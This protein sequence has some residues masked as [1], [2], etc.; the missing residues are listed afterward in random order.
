MTHQRNSNEVIY[1]KITYQHN[2][3]SIRKLSEYLATLVEKIEEQ[4]ERISYLEGK[5][6]RC[7]DEISELNR[8]NYDFQFR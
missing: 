5:V 8:D 4:Q 7:E 3:L 1:D 2:D 6:S